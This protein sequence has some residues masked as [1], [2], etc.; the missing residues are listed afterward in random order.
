MCIF[1]VSAVITQNVDSL[2]Y[3]AG[4]KNVIELHGSAYKVICLTCHATYNR[5]YIQDKLKQMNPN[6]PEASSMIR[7]DGDVDIPKVHFPKFITKQDF[8]DLNFQENIQNFHPPLCESCGEILKPD[9]TFFGDNV[10]LDLVKL[11]RKTVSNSDGLLILGSSLAVFSGYRIVLQ[12]V[13]EGKKV[14]IINIGPTRADKMVNFKIS[15]RCGDILPRI[16]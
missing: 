10:S 7:P 16:C 12:A 15:S 8:I 2:H 14:G 4:S 11:I 6:M 5:F 9:I 3:K 1:Q 13:E